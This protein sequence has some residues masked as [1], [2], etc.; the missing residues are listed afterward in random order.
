MLAIYHFTK[1]KAITKIEKENYTLLTC[2]NCGN[3][4][5]FSGTMDM[6]CLNHDWSALTLSSQENHISCHQWLLCP[7]CTNQVRIAAG[8]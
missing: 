5:E 7:S 3:T 2:R 8:L 6:D 4:E 1:E